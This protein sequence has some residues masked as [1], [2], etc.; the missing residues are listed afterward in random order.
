MKDK[1]VYIAGPM[2]GRPDLGRGAFNRAEMKLRSRGCKVI[3]PACLPI[4]LPAGSYAP[5]CLAMLMQCN[6]IC[7]LPGWEDSP[8]AC[9][10][11]EVA[12]YTGMTVYE[13]S[14]GEIG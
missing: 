13:M 1:V 12:L 7:L 6:E 3:N 2:S 10:E 8:G 14:E 11:H 4:D 9:M 5:I